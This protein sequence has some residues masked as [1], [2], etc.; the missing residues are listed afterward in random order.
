MS[1]GVSPEVL[2]TPTHLL[3]ESERAAFLFTKKD[4]GNIGILHSDDGDDNRRRAVGMMSEVTGAQAVTRLKTAM[5]DG[6][7]H[8]DI[9]GLAA[10]E[11][12]EVVYAEALIT[13]D[14]DHI[15]QV[16][17]ADCLTLAVDGISERVGGPVLALIHAAAKDIV[18]GRPRLTLEYMCATYS[19]E[20]SE[21][22]VKAS[23][24]ARH[25]SYKF[26]DIS[27]HQKQS[28]RWQDYVYQ[29]EA[30]MWHVDFHGRAMAD[31]AELGVP[32]ANIWANP[33]D[34]ISNPAYFS[35]YRHIQH[36]DVRGYNGAFAALMPTS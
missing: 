6:V 34:T 3:V 20:P 5:P 36:G 8:L 18:A 11:L 9:S 22:Q 2:D 27:E 10:D 17:P 35:Y 1:R 16:N 25:Q 29:D 15:L 19:V 23:P 31:L 33:D 32:N 4:F 30:G 7:D 26:K 28:E 24:T 21:L 14:P 13:T 12:P